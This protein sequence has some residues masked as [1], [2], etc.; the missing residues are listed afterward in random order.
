MYRT[1]RVQYEAGS[2]SS[3]SSVRDVR[4]PV[5]SVT[6]GLIVWIIELKVGQNG[7]GL[8]Q[9]TYF[10]KFWSPSTATGNVTFL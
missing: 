4:R 1:L 9:K 8:R 5:T 6:S 2:G 10:K 3:F 7:H